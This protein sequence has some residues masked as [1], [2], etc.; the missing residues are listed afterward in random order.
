MESDEEDE[1]NHVGRSPT[2]DAEGG[3]AETVVNA[4]GG[5]CGWSRAPAGG[6]A[7]GCRAAAAAVQGG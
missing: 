6:G 4:G 1:G 2:A 5:A 3:G 7:S